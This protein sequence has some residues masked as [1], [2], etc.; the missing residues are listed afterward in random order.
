MRRFVVAIDAAMAQGEARD[1]AAIDRAIQEGD[2][3]IALE[4]LARR[5]PKRWAKR[6]GLDITSGGEKVAPVQVITS[7]P[8]LVEI[9][10]A[11]EKRARGDGDE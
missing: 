9:L 7:N 2:A 8:Q 6:D 1:V 10:A 4:R 11:Q 5:H 3:K